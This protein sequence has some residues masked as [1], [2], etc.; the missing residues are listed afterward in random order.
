M[1]SFSGEAAGSGEAV[2]EAMR[3]AAATK[4]PVH[5]DFESPPRRAAG[6]FVS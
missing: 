1:I 6:G 3:S 5:L 2:A 4:I